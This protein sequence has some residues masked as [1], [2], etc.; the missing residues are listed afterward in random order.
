[1]NRTEYFDRLYRQNYEQL[2]FF[3]RQYVEDEEACHDIVTSV[4]EGV[5]KAI[6]R[7]AG[8]E[9][10][11]AK[12]YLF[13]TTRNKCMN[14]LRHQ[15]VHQRYVEL[16]M[17]L[18]SY[19]ESPEEMMEVEELQNEMERRINELG[20]PTHEIFIACYV[21]RKRYKEVANEMG[22][23]V[24]TVRKHI[25]KALKFFSKKYKKE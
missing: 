8:F 19:C 4:F 6:D 9:Q 11:A 10:E 24:S 16:C 18:S 25:V 3:A 7:V 14:H 2:Y 21:D 17:Q 23:S 15:K 1:M 22:I 5:W 12:Y 20:P 13:T